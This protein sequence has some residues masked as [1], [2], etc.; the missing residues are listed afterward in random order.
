MVSLITS[1][2]YIRISNAIWSLRERPVCRRP[3]AA[4]TSWCSRLSMFMCRSSREVSQGS[5]PP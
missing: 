4:P 3:A 1:L 2:V 5:Y